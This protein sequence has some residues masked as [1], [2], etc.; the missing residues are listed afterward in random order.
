MPRKSPPQELPE[1]VADM[2]AEDIAFELAQLSWDHGRVYHAI[3]LD[4]PVRDYLVSALTRQTTR[5]D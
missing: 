4:E 3:K 2:T 1:L 5:R